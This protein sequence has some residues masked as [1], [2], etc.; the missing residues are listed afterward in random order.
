MP[1]DFAARQ[2][3]DLKY[4]FIDIQP[5]LLRRSFLDEGADP[6][7]DFA[8]SMAVCDDERRRLPGLLQVVSRKPAQTGAGVIHNRAERLVEL[9]RNRG[10]HLSQSRHPSDMRQLRLRLTQRFFGLLALNKL[11]DL[12]SD[13][14]QRGE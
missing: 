8:G 10:R 12:A 2:G 11:P 6:A 9:V 3:D 13:G 1:L 4:S 14:R 7:D 5:S